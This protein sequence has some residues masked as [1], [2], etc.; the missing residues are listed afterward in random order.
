M[1]LSDDKKGCFEGPLPTAIT[2]M[3]KYKNLLYLI[4]LF[5]PMSNMYL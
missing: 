5:Y 1:S 2:L 3:K 4:F